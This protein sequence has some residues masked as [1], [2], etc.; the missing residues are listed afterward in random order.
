MCG[1]A[2]ANSFRR[3]IGLKE[4]FWE[5]MKQKKEKERERDTQNEQSFTMHYLLLVFS[6]K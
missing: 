3:R 5:E 4:V 1:T 2:T 6:I